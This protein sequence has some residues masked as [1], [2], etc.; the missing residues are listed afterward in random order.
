MRGKQS[1]KGIYKNLFLSLKMGNVL[2]HLGYKCNK[3]DFHDTSVNVFSF[4]AFRMCL[5]ITL[6]LVNDTVGTNTNRL[7]AD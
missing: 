1:E 5:L 2:L 6:Q 3:N 4:H 7:F